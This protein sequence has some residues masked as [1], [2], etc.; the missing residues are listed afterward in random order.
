MNFGKVLLL[1][2]HFDDEALGCGGLLMKLPAKHVHVRYF[3]TVHPSVH[4]DTYMKEAQS[5]AQMA[6]FVASVSP[7]TGVNKLDRYPIAEFVDD[8]EKIINVIQ[9]R[10]LL[11]PHV[12][13]N[14]DRRVIF[15]AA[16]TASRMHDTN[17]YVKN[18]L[19]YEQPETLHT[20]RIEP[21]FV[22]H[23]FVPIN[24]EDKL[25]LFRLYKSQQRGHRTEDHLRYLAGLRGM[26]C[27]QPYAEA[28]MVIRIT[29]D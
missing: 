19:I 28:F 13:Y 11:V 15:E 3:N 9:P 4:H 25:D 26:Q 2:P 17:W 6:G 5:V 21:R 27:N 1:S 18:I 7:L 29:N 14:Q 24:I 12:S 20:N 22:P 23:V 8:I 10:T 16:I